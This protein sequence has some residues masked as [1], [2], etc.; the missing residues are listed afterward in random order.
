MIEQEKARLGPQIKAFRIQRLNSWFFLL[1]AT[2]T[3][4]AVLLG[5]VRADA[6][7]C[8]VVPLFVFG[9][10]TVEFFIKRRTELRLFEHGLEYQRLFRKHVVF[11]DDIEEFGHILRSDYESADLRDERGVPVPK[12]RSIRRGSDQVWL[13]TVNG[14][15]FYLRADLEN[16]KEIIDMISVKLFGEPYYDS[17]ADAVYTS[18]KITRRDID[19]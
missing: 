13:Q 5:L 16:I 17:E 10:V 9:W 6:P 11:W 4:A 18:R 3:T 8:A 7:V 1:I 2:L 15:W 14:E 12:A 19:A